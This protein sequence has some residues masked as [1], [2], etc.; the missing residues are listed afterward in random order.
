[1][2]YKDIEM[3]RK[4]NRRYQ[5]KYQLA[6]ILYYR[7]KATEQRIRV[8]TFVENIKKNNKC[9]ICGI[10][11]FRCLQFHHPNPKKKEFE[12]AVL[13]RQ[14]S[15]KKLVQEIE[16]CIILC[17]NCHRKLHARQR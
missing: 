15:M 1:M 4:T 7:Q 17:A 3:R 13:A 12:V 5:R 6:H 2:P 10:D 11:D 8:L 9:T 16:K 14:G